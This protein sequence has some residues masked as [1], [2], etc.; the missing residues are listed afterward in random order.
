MSSVV[1][2]G[3][4]GLCRGLVGL[5]LYSVTEEI[6]NC[7]VYTRGVKS[8]V[9][10]LVEYIEKTGGNMSIF[11]IVLFIYGILL[12]AGGY[13]GYAK[14]GSK[15]S[16]IMGLISGALILLGVYLLGTNFPVG[17]ILV[18]SVSLLLCIVFLL[19]LI[20]THQFMPAG[21]LLVLSVAVLLLCIARISP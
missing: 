16:L 3:V 19:R 8:Q 12:I 9:C 11:K 17:R 21:M 15:P 10:G 7:G 18:S 4:S 5:I 13:L 1:Y 2:S 20:K 14:A 6:Q